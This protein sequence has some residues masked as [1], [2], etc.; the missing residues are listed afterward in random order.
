MTNTFKP[1]WAVL[2]NDDCLAWFRFRDDADFYA[3]SIRDLVH[4][5]HTVTVERLER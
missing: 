1:R 4:D 5:G 2:E 3:T